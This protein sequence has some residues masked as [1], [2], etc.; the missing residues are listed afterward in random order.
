[1]FLLPSRDGN[2]VLSV[3]RKQWGQEVWSL[4]SQACFRD[5]LCF[6]HH[7]PCNGPQ[8]HPITCLADLLRR[9]TERSF[10]RW[11]YITGGT[12]ARSSILKTTTAPYSRVFCPWTHGWIVSSLILSLLHL[13]T[14]H[15]RSAPPCGACPGCCC[16]CCCSC[17]CSHHHKPTQN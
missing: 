2:S 4:V 11:V 14:P 1:M 3:T 8:V 10:T 6:A 16:C 5:L 17:C 7:D 15:L 9:P 13:C 12:R